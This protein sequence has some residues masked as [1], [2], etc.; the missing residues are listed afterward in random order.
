MLDQTVGPTTEQLQAVRDL[1]QLGFGGAIVEICS[2]LE[3][4][5][6]WL[7]LAALNEVMTVDA[8]NAKI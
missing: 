7:E 8:A 3:I 6:M 2:R 5:G 4:D 1:V